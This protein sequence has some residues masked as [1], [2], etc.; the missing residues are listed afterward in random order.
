MIP[1][2]SS[3][4][5]LLM[6]KT[7]VFFSDR[8]R[9]FQSFLKQKHLHGGYNCYNSPC[10]TCS[11]WWFFL[12]WVK[13]TIFPGVSHGFHHASTKAC[14]VAG[15]AALQR[16]PWRPCC[17]SANARHARHARRRR[18]RWENP[19][20]TMGTH[21]KTHGKT[22]GNFSGKPWAD[23]GWLVMTSWPGK[24]GKF[25]WFLDGTDGIDGIDG[26]EIHGV[27]IFFFWD[28]WPIKM[29]YEWDSG[30]LI[31]IDG[32]DIRMDMMEMIWWDNGIIHSSC[33][34]RFQL[35]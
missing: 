14:S 20:E 27:F 1:I 35:T 6:S 22:M 31:W 33:A 28:S 5:F 17:G 15:C 9:S 24:N 29:G 21:G 11:G 12:F 13:P 18:R 34:C 23:W 30:G 32:N 10:W 2:F 4:W 25:W 16:P 3:I 26:W 19:W 7:Q 8:S